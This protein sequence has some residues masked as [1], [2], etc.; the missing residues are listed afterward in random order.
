M[1]YAFTLAAAL[2]LF[3]CSAAAS[4]GNAMVE[5]GP[6]VTEPHRLT[7]HP[8]EDYQPAVSPAGDVLAFVSNRAGAPNIW[9]KTIGRPELPTPKRLTSVASG[10][11]SP[12]FSPDGRMIVYVSY[13]SDAEGD[14]YLIRLPKTK[15][16]PGFKP[17]PEKLTDSTTADK[18]PVFT[19][20]GD[21]VI[22]TSSDK[23]GGAEN[24]WL[25]DLKTRE[26]KRL[27]SD[28]GAQVAISQDGNLVAFVSRRGGREALYTLDLAAGKETMI[29]EDGW[30]D[31]FPAFSAGRKVIFSRYSND[32]NLD[33]RISLEDS[34]SLFIKDVARPESPA[35]QL[36]T[37]ESYDLFPTVSDGRLFYS[38]KKGAAVDVLSLPAGG[39]LAASG[40]LKRDMESAR[41]VEK[42]YP[43]RPM[44]ALLAWNV[45]WSSNH[46]SGDHESLA[47][48]LMNAAG[49]LEKT[50]D[51]AGADKVLTRLVDRYPGASPWSGL[52]EVRRALVR[53]QLYRQSPDAT[54]EK[55]KEIESRY[56]G[57]RQV[58]ARA[59]I[60]QASAHISAG[61][62][63]TGL[64]ILR[65]VVEEFSD[66]E[67]LAA[68]A[69]FR[70]NEV[71]L[72]I[73]DRERLT[74]TYLDV[75]RNWQDQDVWVEKAIS[76]ILDIA[77]VEG[78]MKSSLA[79]LDGIV[80]KYENL[81]ALQAEAM[82]RIA[83]LYYKENELTRAGETYA[84]TASR[85]PGQR[86]AANE[87]LFSMARIYVEKEEYSKALEVYR[88]IEQDTRAKRDV[89][90]ESR[91]EFIRQSISKGDYEF[92]QGE[93]RVALKT[94]KSVMD[95]EPSVTQAHRGLIR[96]RAA[97]GEAKRAVDDYERLVRGD[98]KNDVYLYSLGLA[99][100]YLSPPPLE[101][102]EEL[103]KKALSLNEKDSWYH[104]TLGW[105][106][107][108]KS[109][110]NGDDR[111]AELALQE[112]QYALALTDTENDP[113]READLLLNIGNV[114]FT[115]GACSDAV[116][117]YSA[118]MKSGALFT[119]RAQESV[120]HQR[121]GICAY[122]LGDDEE[123]E[124]RL[125]RALE[126]VDES[127]GARKIE[128]LERL[129]LV[130]QSAG[131]H[132]LAA[133]V[134]MESLKLRRELGAKGDETVIL[135]N[136][137][138]NL[139]F[140]SQT[141][142]VEDTS[143]LREALEYYKR[144][145]ASLK[146]FKA[147]E[148][149]K[150]KA[151]VTVEVETGAGGLRGGGGFSERDEKKLIF[152]HIG[153]IYGELGD[154][155]KAAEYF[156]RKLEL[157]PSELPLL[158][159]V[160][161]LTEKAIVLNQLG[162]YLAK[163]GKVYEAIDRF[164]DSL[165]ICVKLAS[166]AGI[167]TNTDNMARLLLSK[168][169]ESMEDRG[170]AVMEHA[171]QAMKIALEERTADQK[172]LSDA[173]NHLGQLYHRR[174]TRL[175]SSP[176]P[177]E[178][179]EHAGMVKKMAADAN[180]AE[181][182]YRQ[183]RSSLPEKKEAPI[184]HAALGI[185]I[186]LARLLNDTGWTKEARKTLEEAGA[187]AEA[188]A[189]NDL[190]WQVEYLRYRISGAERI[191]DLKAVASVLEKLPLGY[192]ASE[193]QELVMAMIR[194]MYHE[195]A[196]T[197]FEKKGAE[198]ALELL[199]RGAGEAVKFSLA[200]IARGGLGDAAPPEIRRLEELYEQREAIV[201]RLVKE[202]GAGQP[203]GE[204]EVSP[205]AEVA[206][207]RT[208]YE[209]HIN[210]LRE[211]NGLLAEVAWP[212]D[213][214]LEKVRASLDENEAAVKL[215]PKKD[216]L[217][218]FVMTKDG[219]AT[220][221]VPGQREVYGFL[222]S[223]RA[224]S[225]AEII[226]AVTDRP[227]SDPA[228]KL[229]GDRQVAAVP[230]FSSIAFFKERRS[231]NDFRLLVIGEGGPDTGALASS[232]LDVHSV[233]GAKAEQAL[234]KN[235]LRET[236]VAV[237]A[238]AP[239]PGVS[240]PL[241]TVLDATGPDGTPVRFPMSRVVTA[242]AEGSLI[243]TPLLDAEGGRDWESGLL[244]LSL[245]SGF[246]SWAQVSDKGAMSGFLAELREKGLND[247]ASSYKGKISMAGSFGFTK[248]EKIHHARERFANKIQAGV[249]AVQGKRWAEAAN[250]L[251]QALVYTKVAG[252]EKYEEPLLDRLSDVEF[253]LGRYERSLEHQKRLN[254]IRRAAG[255]VPKLADSLLITGV[256]QTKLRRYE[257]AVASMSEALDIYRSEGMMEKMASASANLGLAEEGFARYGRALEAF[258]DALG[259]RRRMG[260]EINSATELRRIGRIYH[261]R[262]NLFD[263][264]R[265]SYKEALALYL[266]AGD[267][268]SALLS[269]IE[270]GALEED[271][272]N[273]EEAEK[274]FREA[275]EK[276][277][278]QNDVKLL[279]LAQ[280]HLGNVHWFRGEYEPAYTWI[281]KSIKR[282]EDEGDA[283]QQ[284]ISLNT[285]G[286]IHWTLNDYRKA[287]EAL[288]K[289]LALARESGARLDEGSALN[290]I[291]LVYRNMGELER[292]IDY[293][294]QAL[295]IDEELGSKWAMA[296]DARNM[297][298]SRLLMKDIPH[299]EELARRAVDLSTE[300]GDKVNTAKSRL[301]LAEVMA[302]KEDW[303]K[304]YPEFEKVWKE[305]GGAGLA[306]VEW[307]A[308]RGVGRGLAARGDRE[309]AIEAYKKA[310]DVVERMRASIKIEEL[311]SGF[312][313]DKQDLYEEL[314]LLLLDQND[315]KQAFGY[316]ERSR[317]RG[318]I[319]ILGTAKIKLKDEESQKE[320][321]RIVSL[322]RE[323][324]RLLRAAGADG[325]EEELSRR[326]R[327][328]S[329]KI[330]EAI[331][332]L[333]VERPE[334]LQFV[335]VEPVDADEVMAAMGTQ[336]ALIEYMV[337]EKEV[338]IFVV[339]GKGVSA[340]RS[341][342]RRDKLS[343]LVTRYR[344]IIQ[345]RAP[346]GDEPE[347]LG[348]ILLR[349]V[350]GMIE[351]AEVI[352]IAPH[353]ALHYLSFASIKPDGNYLI[354]RKP[355]FY[356]PS[357]SVFLR[358]IKRRVEDGRERKKV[359]AVGNPALGSFD[360]DLPL[361]ELEAKSI[362]WV[363][364]EVEVIVR[365]EATESRVTK[366]APDYDILHIASH[367]QFE[368]ENP[369]E[370][371]LFLSPDVENDGTLKV[372]EVFYMDLNADLVTLS[373]C[374][375][376]LGE[377]SRGDDI[378]GLNRAF[379]YSGARSIV[380]T[381]WRVD[382]MASA[383]LVKHFYRELVQDDKAAAL[384]KAQLLVKHRFPHPSFWAGF[385]LVGDYR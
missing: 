48:C 275:L 148:A 147:R 43:D 56:S 91:R 149:A 62:P 142:G 353:R 138:N 105:V 42:Y 307:R 150:S 347:R 129:G 191:E 153:R 340:V 68:E 23:K 66:L 277:G 203:A 350:M 217:V 209:N 57:L 336:A 120:F 173:L 294:G 219:L 47:E 30:A 126:L 106:Y 295:K 180:R 112:Y 111:L 345:D 281:R 365:E 114:S 259:T 354:D 61:R 107:E 355:V 109:H 337:T 228:L 258:E 343:E 283:A 190:L 256:I 237:F 46:D 124:R 260:D 128:L 143:T 367:G 326:R 98:P 284:T 306:E 375:T 49:I 245:M 285:L 239:R 122:R 119:S 238:Q 292:S 311:K 176:I 75:I 377:V 359:M 5:G 248:E 380:S 55:L 144:S 250:L 83:L 230:S 383:I 302:A 72:E 63:D 278:E 193:S 164:L 157:T 308:A 358:A 261:L 51:K 88:S 300:I 270:L 159:N 39:M 196:A 4:A 316:A 116:D 317:A 104:Q 225:G 364:P 356:T 305:A 175:S 333:R 382:D 167:V 58:A 127:E 189:M 27:T 132:E 243:V 50:G 322:K 199:E 357:A 213:F 60:E 257:D 384:R 168:T 201:D 241:D 327:E 207:W 303:E 97:L 221:V 331:E 198:S 264:A 289:S 269:L 179:V 131:R 99:L 282:A 79:N 206:E 369:L 14:L 200:G 32:T 274:I 361:S 139:Y 140:L 52:A 298:I 276:A 194:T 320:Y 363:F 100:T 202:S 18:E 85:F 35:V 174:Y 145:E 242:G 288:E 130:R 69:A 210:S 231:I 54:I 163:T 172:A 136:I 360:T 349:P 45:A 125:E 280:F 267:K 26:R 17:T 146:D 31:M 229:F 113:K 170:S 287:L 155:G 253:T 67:G 178:P 95:Y 330:S 244:T 234:E 226:Y 94:F 371:S 211:K 321:E 162:V 108:Q 151:L 232:Y 15:D 59:R 208:G 346:I 44:L 338:V 188:F 28:G 249:A 89:F 19:P 204:P 334:V 323:L 247:A 171:F 214:D 117:S 313:D 34:P 301:Q 255:D 103:M 161:V 339:T 90:R 74:K 186:N 141:K 385:T 235:L 254:E 192:G 252:V 77:I 152:H 64:K 286:L 279:A 134:F 21:A 166:G 84:I 263:K 218:V 290:N 133:K 92:S 2:A 312:L 240:N 76:R 373:A 342:A 1:R 325:N 212:S 184:A 183:A 121:W 265:E 318:F 71:Y 38:S 187:R 271:A 40:S 362:K 25:M 351:D 182:L 216:A 36:T 154:Y 379:M 24:L 233:A 309:G 16:L 123:A 381:L 8:A 220:E 156:E 118:R 335:T 299:A 324:E 344:M 81:P 33:G 82:N 96:A 86:K 348:E 158:D 304:A 370:S 378:V 102:S 93:I 10:D 268:S 73:G 314:I 195:Q 222:S 110:A 197:A 262:L 87:A 246:P 22:F 376:G 7:T 181:K 352:G 273:L 41:M 137:A 101:R 315:V 165:D 297:S 11:K 368:P 372:D 160:P 224:L 37:G 205:Q 78:D 3:F 296:Y 272:G 177:A 266:K 329:G 366:N 341:P 332:R 115:L 236:G 12:A 9:I 169:A 215:W 65:G 20:D 251:E 319:D 293:F 80:E 310:V 70:R 291:G 13:G 223:Y 374:Q 6:S 185:T 328:V 135:R 227:F 29:T 53:A